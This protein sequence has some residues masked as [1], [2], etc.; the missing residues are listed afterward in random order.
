M[1]H[2][3]YIAKYLWT[4]Q[5]EPG[6]QTAEC[7]W[8]CKLYNKEVFWQLLKPFHWSAF[9]GWVHGDSFPAEYTRVLYKT[10]MIPPVWASV[11]FDTTFWLYGHVAIADEGCTEH[12]LCTLSQNS[13]GKAGDPP[14]DEIIRKKYGYKWVLWWYVHK[15]TPTEEKPQEEPKEYESDIKNVWKQNVEKN[16][17]FKK[18]FTD[19]NDKKTCTIA[20]CKCL[21]DI[22]INQSR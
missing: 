13:S 1:N 4:F 3:E 20:D 9:S 22:A 2:T 16:P 15:D 10:G 12:E 7:V 8:N 5:R 11:F 6:I 17:Y 21:L 19:Y 18:H 14:W